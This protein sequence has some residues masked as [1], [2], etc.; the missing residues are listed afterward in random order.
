MILCLL[1]AVF[2]IEAKLAWY[3]PDGGIT[4]PI[5]ASKLQ[6]ADAPRRVA[7][8]IASSLPVLHVPEISVMLLAA[9]A[10]GAERFTPPVETQP[11]KLLSSQ[12]SPHLFFRPPPAC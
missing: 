5:S 7:Q 11:V 2:A 10:I 12:L 1:A 8:A 9:L 6:A 4:A 3:V